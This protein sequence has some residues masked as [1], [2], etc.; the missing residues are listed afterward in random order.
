[1]TCNLCHAVI[2]RHSAIN[3]GSIGEVR[4]SWPPIIDTAR[5]WVEAQEYPPTQRQLYYRLVATQLIPNS[6]SS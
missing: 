1:M 5:A 4:L 2:R 3:V 6:E